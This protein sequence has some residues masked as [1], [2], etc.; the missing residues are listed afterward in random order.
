MI[1]TLFN[2]FGKETGRRKQGEF[3]PYTRQDTQGL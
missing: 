2:R 1:W 3:L